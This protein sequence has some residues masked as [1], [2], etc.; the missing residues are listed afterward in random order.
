MNAYQK[1]VKYVIPQ[2]KLQSACL[3]GGGTTEGK[4]DGPSKN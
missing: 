2:L 4:N 1:G 3:T